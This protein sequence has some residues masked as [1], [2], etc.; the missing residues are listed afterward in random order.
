MIDLVFICHWESL[1][2]VQIF[3]HLNHQNHAF[4]IKKV[5]VSQTQKFDHFQSF[6]QD[7]HVPLK[8]QFKY[9]SLNFENVSCF[10]S[11]PWLWQNCSHQ[12]IATFIS[13]ID[14]CLKSSS[15][16]FLNLCCNNWKAQILFLN[17]YKIYFNQ[18]HFT[19][20]KSR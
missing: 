9:C 2:T 6:L 14:S 10:T 4:E 19:K 18:L 16:S 11:S 1:C 13:F 12:Q 20:F 3:R 15:F 5:A 17:N 7:C 8:G